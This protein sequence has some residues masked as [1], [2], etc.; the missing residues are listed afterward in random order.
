MGVE[1]LVS[2]EGGAGGAGGEAQDNS[3]DWILPSEAFEQRQVGLGTETGR[4]RS[5]DK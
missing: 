3:R 1:H 4:N 5:R 2:L